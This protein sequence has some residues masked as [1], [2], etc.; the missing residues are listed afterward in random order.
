MDEYNS[1]VIA[2]IVRSISVGVL[3]SLVLVLSACGSGFSYSGT[4]KGNRNIKPLAGE[5]PAVARTLGQ[6]TLVIEG[7]T[8]KLSEAGIPMKGTVRYSG[9]KAYL[10]IESRMDTPIASEPAEVQ[11][12]FKQEVVLTPL[13]D[14]KIEYHDPGGFQDNLTLERQKE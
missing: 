11:E 7:G 10:K 5:S 4:W 13:E 2:A 6:V 9:G 14:G 12:Q 8:F 3:G 1:A